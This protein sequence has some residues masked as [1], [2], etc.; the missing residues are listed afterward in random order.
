[1]ISTN[2]MHSDGLRLRGASQNRQMPHMIRSCE[3]ESEKYNLGT[4]DLTDG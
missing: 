4:M 2:Q 3:I 1:M